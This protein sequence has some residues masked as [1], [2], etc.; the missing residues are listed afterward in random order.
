MM[1]LGLNGLYEDSDT[2][3]ANGNAG[4]VIADITANLPVLIGGTVTALAYGGQRGGSGFTNVAL[5]GTSAG[6][7]FFRGE[8]AAAFTN[9][10]GLIGG[11]GAGSVQSIAIDPLDWRQVYVAK[12]NQIFFTPNITNLGANPFTL[13][14]G[15]AN[16]NLNSLTSQFQSILVARPPQSGNAPSTVLLAAQGGVFRLGTLA[17]GGPATWASYGAGLPKTVVASLIYDVASNKLVAGTFGRGAW[18]SQ[19]IAPAQ[20]LDYAFAGFNVVGDWDRVDQSQ[21]NSGFLESRPTAAVSKYAKWD[22]NMLSPPPAI[23]QNSTYPVEAF[24][25]FNRGL[26][27]A[28]YSYTSEVTVS[29]VKGDVYKFPQGGPVGNVDQGIVAGWQTIGNINVSIPH[30]VNGDLVATGNVT[31]LIVSVNGGQNIV[32][33]AL[34]INGLTFSA[35]LTPEFSS[36]KGDWIQ[37]GLQGNYYRRASGGR[38]EA[39]TW[40]VSGL[41]PGASYEIS[42][43]WLNYDTLA[44]PYNPARYF[45]YDGTPT[46]ATGT[47]DTLRRV[48]SVDQTALPIDFM[49]AGV[50][51]KRLG[52]IQVSGSTLTV[53]LSA[54]ADAAVIAAAIR[55]Q[56]VHGNTAQDDD[57]HLPASS[58]AIDRGNVSDYSYAEPAPS[59]DRADL[60]AYGN[61]PQSAPSP[62]QLVQVMSPSGRE[63]LQ[64]GQQ[65]A[66]NWRSAGLTQERPVALIDAGSAT[67]TDNSGADIFQTLYT[68]G[69]ITQAVNTSGVADILPQAV[70]QSYAQA[71]TFG[72]DQGNLSYQFAVPDG[73]YTMRLHFVEPN[74]FAPVGQRKFNIDLQGTTVLANYDIAADAGASFKATE[75]TFVVTAAGGSGISLRLVTKS[76]NQSYLAVISAIEIVAANPNGV[77]TPTFNLELS[78][79]G[80]ATWSPLASGLSVDRYGRGNYL[81]TVPANLAPGNQYLVRVKANDGTHPQGVSD[82]KFLVASAGH[83]FYVN[84]GATVGDVFT[85]AVGDNASSGKS[86]AA[87]MAS[88]AALIAAYQPHAGDVIHVDTGTY[89]QLTNVVLTAANSGLRIEGPTSGIALLDRNNRAYTSYGFELIHATNITL[90]HLQ[91][92]HASS[93]VNAANGSQSTGLVI[94][95]SVIYGNDFNGVYLGASNDGAAITGSTLYGFPGQSFFSQG[96]GINVANANDVTIT[97]NRIYNSSSIISAAGQRITVSGNEIYGGGNAFQLNGSGTISNNRV[98]DNSG[99]GIIASSSPGSLLVTGNTV[100][101]HP[102]NQQ[103][104]IRG[105]GAEIRGNTVYDNYDGIAGDFVVGN[106][107]YH[108]AHAGIVTTGTAKGNVAYSNAFGLVLTSLFSS[109]PILAANNIIYANSSVGIDVATITQNDQIINNTVYQPAGDALRFEGDAGVT[110][111]R[112]TNTTIRNNLL[113]AQ[114]G[115]DIFVP[116][117]AEGDLKSDYNN[118]YTS[119]AAKFG[120][121][122]ARDFTDLASW[123][124]ETG[125]DQHSLIANPQFVSPAGP[126]GILGYDVINGIDRSFD[127]D[128][129]VLPGS[130]MIDR[131]DPTDPYFAEPTPNGNRIEIGGYGNTSGAT[132][133]SPQIVQVITPSPNDKLQVGQQVAINWRSAGLTSQRPVALLDAGGGPVDN[134]ARDTV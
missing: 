115:Y 55:V 10:T 73:A 75:K 43:T 90:D 89:A 26:S 109:T 54:Q 72:S 7:L 18:S 15:G 98:H 4:D 122:Q 108:N 24:W 85:T 48:A 69:S 16:D 60:G 62:S 123:F 127:D 58:P 105:T 61:T 114:A 81:W 25:G 96:T 67:A 57:F 94:S 83:D 112:V 101:G 91:I 119:G 126:D 88:L 32:A 120:N 3:I 41:T 102:G 66:I 129:H 11:L 2:N 63:K 45:L 78:D 28:S 95:N 20:I 30:D 70:Y 8:S 19:F 65:F 34:R 9:A 5:V 132:P 79:N 117:S 125:Q 12:A 77:A 82:D 53:K 37:G 50:G 84:D 47:A 51:W 14:G 130:A 104:G 52:V 110:G 107:A 39:A 44:G 35:K 59:G 68:R 93:G 23:G 33:D 106:R 133:G 76:A 6:Q 27:G 118:L 17:P 49:D 42:S 46:T 74:Q 97:N 121:W 113:W 36:G 128:F 71:L 111:G 56:Q 21:G 103:I 80:G 99:I 13:I 22:A 86:P 1:L 87:P 29:T 64:A 134:W 31:S 116:A 40:T 124:Y 131:G 100:Y 38:D 92:A